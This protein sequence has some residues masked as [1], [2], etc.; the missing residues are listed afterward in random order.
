MT[1]SSWEKLVL[2]DCSTICLELV[3]PVGAHSES[4]VESHSC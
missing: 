1:F 4:W 3:F 2:G